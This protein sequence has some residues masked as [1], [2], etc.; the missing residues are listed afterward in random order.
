MSPPS[1]SSWSPTL[2]LDRL[3][4]VATKRFI[5][6]QSFR[7]VTYTLVQ[8]RHLLPNGLKKFLV[9]NVR[10]LDLLLM[11]NKTFAAEIAHGVSSRNRT[12]IL[13]RYD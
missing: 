1:L 12:T 8:T 5:L 3:V 6:F 4:T 10:E 11:H 2:S 7:V 9:N 13:G